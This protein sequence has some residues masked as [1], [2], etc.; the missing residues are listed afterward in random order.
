M[1]YV[2]LTYLNGLLFHPLPSLGGRKVVPPPAMC[3]QDP[4]RRVFEVNMIS[5]WNLLEAAAV[6]GIEKIVNITLGWPGRRASSL[7]G[8][9]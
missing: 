5:N 7:E 6:L 4:E 3:S 1:I 8:P 2:C 9:I